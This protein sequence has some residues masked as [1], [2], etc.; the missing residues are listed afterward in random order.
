M[1]TNENAKK[2]LYIGAGV[3]LAAFAVAGLLPG[4]FIGGLIGL[5]IAGSIAGTPVSATLLPRLIVGASMVLGIM[6]SGTIFVTSASLLGRLA[7]TLI[8]SAQF[9]RVARVGAVVKSR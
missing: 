1:K 3:G 7:G 9:S 5:N 4:S 8:D 2:G 6:I